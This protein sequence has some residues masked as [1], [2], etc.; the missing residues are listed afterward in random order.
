[1]TV[2]GLHRKGNAQHVT[3]MCLVK[4]TA[5]FLFWNSQSPEVPDL[6]GTTGRTLW[7][8]GMVTGHICAGG[9]EMEHL[10]LSPFSSLRGGII[11]GLY[12]LLNNYIEF[13]PE[14]IAAMTAA[15]NDSLRNLGLADVSD[16]IT[17]VVAER[18]IQFAH[19][20]ER[21]AV[22]LRELALHSL[23]SP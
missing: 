10:W 8:T 14:V 6:A 17:E 7:F 18:I 16:P 5:H 2:M 22:R 11:V 9:D 13:D 20:G 15:Y 3:T 21:D 1:M 4:N 12:R 23:R 19:R